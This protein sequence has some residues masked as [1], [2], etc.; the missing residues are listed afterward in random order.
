MI[1]G[2]WSGPA[3]VIKRKDGSMVT[4]ERIWNDPTVVKLA[5]DGCLMAISPQWLE[6][7]GWTLMGDNIFYSDKVRDNMW[8]CRK[9]NLL[10]TYDPIDDR[11][12]MST[13]LW[14]KNK[15]LFRHPGKINLGEPIHISPNCS[16]RRAMKEFN[17]NWIYTTGS[18]ISSRL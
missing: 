17:F 18:N 10:T 11:I 15:Y 3:R 7:Y 1:D 14:T 5:K 8:Y 4:C 2:F 6:N 9:M 16:S 13:S 12:V